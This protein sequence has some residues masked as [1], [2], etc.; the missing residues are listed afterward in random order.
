MS[1][2]K[3][4]NQQV[5]TPDS[6]PVLVEVIVQV[7]VAH[8]PL[9]NA[10]SKKKDKCLRGDRS[11]YQLNELSLENDRPKETLKIILFIIICASLFQAINVTQFDPVSHPAIIYHKHWHNF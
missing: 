7:F 3:H 5:Q 4:V 8:V 9:V 1:V 2:L 10:D 6:A 11:I